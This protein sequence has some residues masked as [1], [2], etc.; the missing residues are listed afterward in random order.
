MYLAVIE[1]D[2]LE[3]TNNWLIAQGIENE[4]FFTKYLYSLYWSTITILTIGYGDLVPVTN[5]ERIFVILTALI[6]CGVFG[7]SI[8]SIG[9]IFKQLQQKKMAYQSKLKIIN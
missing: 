8:S 7:Y 6:I 3:M 5:P 9:K 1:K 2:Q 4:S